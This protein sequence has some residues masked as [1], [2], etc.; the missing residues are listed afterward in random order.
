[1]RQ[2]DRIEK[3]FGVSHRAV[4]LFRIDV[5]IVLP[6]NL[7]FRR[8]IIEGFAQR[9][10]REEASDRMKTRFLCPFLIPSRWPQSRRKRSPAE[11]RR[12]RG[13]GAEFLARIL[14]AGR[15]T[16]SQSSQ[17]VR[18]K[19]PIETITENIAL[20]H[21]RGAHRASP[22]GYVARTVS[23]ARQRGRLPNPRRP[24]PTPASASRG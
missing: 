20:L 5:T 13:P 19:R 6:T 22:P 17:Q 1:M 11:C 8:P 15:T 4:T 3:W 14:P 23:P 9:I 16:S 2:R 24:K 7:G 21:H 10:G 18:E 12:S